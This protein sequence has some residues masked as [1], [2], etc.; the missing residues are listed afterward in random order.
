LTSADLRG[1]VVLVNFWTYTCINWLRQLPYLRAWA[2][3]YSGQGLVLVG[4]HT[5]EFGFE[6]N[7]DNVARAVRELAI[8]YPV[9]LDDKYEVWNDFG[10]MYWPALYFADADGLLQERHFGEGKYELSERVIQDLLGEPGSDLV[11]VQ[12]DGAE[13]PADWANLRSP[14]TYLSYARTTGFASS[15]GAVPDKPNVYQAPAELRL[16]HWALDGD[17]TVTDQASTSNAAAGRFV[18]RFHSRDLHLVMGPADPTTTVRFRVLLDG[19]PA[20]TGVDVDDQ[21]NGVVTGQRLYQLVRQ[22]GP[23]VDRTFEITFLDAGV[24]I[25]ATTFG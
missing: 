7:A 21:G 1:K 11:A 25:Y 6:G 15:G 19:L 16:N 23:I 4:V 22:P 5:P 18:Y 3:K 12:G 17:W 20:A 13:S 14:E 8:G 2:T 24:E 10:N 9:A